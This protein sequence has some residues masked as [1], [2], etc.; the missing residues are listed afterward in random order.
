LR[1]NSSRYLVNRNLPQ[2]WDR[3]L[4]FLSIFSEIF[5]KVERGD[6]IKVKRF[7]R[8]MLG[9]PLRVSASSTSVS[10][11]FSRS[12][13]GGAKSGAA[14]G[15]GE[16][17]RIAEDAATQDSAIPRDTGEVE[18]RECMGIETPANFPENSTVSSQAGAK[19][20]A[21]NPQNDRSN[22][23]L[24]L[25]VERWDSLPDAVRAGIVAMVKAASAG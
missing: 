15:R 5:S 2:N 6:R 10:G 23:D 8:R 9:Q 17:R 16:W 21:N 13:K 19:S 12:E 20:G 22:P 18:R 14:G 3:I 25:V 24:T 4:V 1:E 7:R 11:A